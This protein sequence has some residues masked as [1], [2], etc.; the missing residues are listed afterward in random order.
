[1]YYVQNRMPK[2]FEVGIFT[3]KQ[4]SFRVICLNL[5]NRLQKFVSL[6]V[7]D[8]ETVTLGACF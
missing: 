8:D 6:N 5:K 4:R 3:I 1:M 7:K 2:T